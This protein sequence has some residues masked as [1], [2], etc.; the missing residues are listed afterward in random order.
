MDGVER[1]AE[2]HRARAERIVLA[3]LHVARQVGSPP[4]HLRRRSPIRPFPLRA[5]LLPAGPAEAVAADADAVAHG[6]TVA[7]DQIQAALGGVDVDAARLVVAGK[8]D[9]RA[10]DL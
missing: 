7:E 10:R 8:A 9:G 5:D 2:I 3:A 1:R 6:L 4:Q